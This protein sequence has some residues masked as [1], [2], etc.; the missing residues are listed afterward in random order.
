M[1]ILLTLFLIKHFICDFPLQTRYQ[2]ENKGVLFHPGGLLHGFITI[3]GSA[4]VLLTWGLES[5][6]LLSVLLCFEF[7]VHYFTDWAKVNINNY[8]GWG[9]LTSPY[10]WWLLGFDQ[11]I[12][13]LTYVFMIWAIYDAFS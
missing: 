9:P 11:L 5:W 1:L 4:I 2:Y 8:Y 6:A 3:A 7:V 13:M 10:F 12:H